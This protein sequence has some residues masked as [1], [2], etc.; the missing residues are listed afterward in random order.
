MVPVI[1]TTKHR[2]VFFGTVPEIPSE[3]SPGGTVSLTDTRMC[4]YWSRAMK[5]ITGL[6]AKG[7]D[8]SCRVSEAVP[9][10]TKLFGVTAIIPVSPKAAEKWEEEPWS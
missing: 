2:G 10:E 1:I 6:A 8:A 4:V 7:P 9:G 5:G 3:L